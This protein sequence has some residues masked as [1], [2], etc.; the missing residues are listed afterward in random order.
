VRKVAVDVVRDLHRV[1]ARTVVHDD[2]LDLILVH[3]I[4]NGS[5]S[6]EACGESKGLVIGRYH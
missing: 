3:L 4:E 2:Y 1:V 6:F 5:Q